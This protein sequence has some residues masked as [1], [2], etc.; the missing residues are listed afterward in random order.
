LFITEAS[1][2]RLSYLKCNSKQ[3]NQD[4]EHKVATTFFVSPDTIQYYRVAPDYFY[5][6]VEYL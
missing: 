1:H 6:S 3:Y 5:R 4:E 2:G